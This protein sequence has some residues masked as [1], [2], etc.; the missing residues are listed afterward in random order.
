MG[1]CSGYFDGY[2]FLTENKKARFDLFLKTRLIIIRALMVKMHI[3][4]PYKFH[5]FALKLVV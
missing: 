3:L 5:L 2:I 4:H 1:V